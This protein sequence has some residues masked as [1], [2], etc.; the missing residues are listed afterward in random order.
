MSVPIS[1]KS[2]VEE[3]QGCYVMIQ[4]WQTAEEKSEYQVEKLLSALQE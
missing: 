1:F 4:P 3:L 2:V